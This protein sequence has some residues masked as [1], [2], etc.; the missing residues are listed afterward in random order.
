MF[1]PTIL[2]S[3]AELASPYV[4]SVAV[5]LAEKEIPYRLE[6]INLEKRENH[7]ALYRNLSL[8]SRVPT[9][10]HGSFQLSESSAIAEYL[11]ETYAAPKYRSLYPRDVEARARARQVQAWLRSDFGPIRLERNTTIIFFGAKMPRLSG[12]AQASA[13]K[14]F[15]AADRLILGSS[16]HLF[17]DWCIA[18]TD[19][20][21]MLN[22]LI[23]NGDSV[24]GKLVRYAH[25]QWQRPSVVEWLGR[26]RT[27]LR[28]AD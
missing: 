24:P 12:P 17:G 23:L 11:D 6:L 20:A 28:K 21:L 8:T 15:E 16:S 4:T 13:E 2:Y 22:R 25:L 18:D 10:V 19:L 27:Q 14:L 3:D 26:H 9:L 7:K 5:A 1:Y